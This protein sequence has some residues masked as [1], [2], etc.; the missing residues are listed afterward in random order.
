[1]DILY[2]KAGKEDIAL[3]VNL[4][5]TVLIA[6]NRLPE[7]TDLSRLDAASAAYFADTEKH[8]TYLAMDGEKVVGVGSVDYHTEMPTVANPT[9]KCAFLMNIYTAPEHRKQ[10]IAT[11]IV[12]L[13]I[14]DAKSRGVGSIMLEATEMGAPLYRRLGFADAHGY[15]QFED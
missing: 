8:T 15:M 3:L 7:D 6:A 12:E 1:M 11:R 9:G 13:L 4:R 2:R 14:G 10:G 5:K